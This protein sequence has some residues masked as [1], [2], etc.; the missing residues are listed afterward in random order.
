[1]VKVTEGIMCVVSGRG[2]AQLILVNKRNIVV[3]TEGLMT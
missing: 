3:V 2:T 1:M